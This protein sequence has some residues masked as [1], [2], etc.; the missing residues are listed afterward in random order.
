MDNLDIR[1][2]NIQQTLQ[3]WLAETGELFV[4]LY[5]PRSGGGGTFYLLTTANH[6]DQLVQHARDG[7]LFFF[8]QQ[9]QFPLRGSVNTAFIEQVETAIAEGEWYLITDLATYP[10]ALAFHGDGN[11]HE[12]L[13]RDLHELRGE[14]IGVGRDPETNPTYWQPDERPDRL[15]AIKRAIESTHK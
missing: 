11:T 4:E 12:Q 10:Q 15:T 6:L 8:L 14:T 7:A 5:Y 9:Q 1:D 2:P 13:M 3:T